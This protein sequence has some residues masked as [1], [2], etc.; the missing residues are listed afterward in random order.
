MQTYLLQRLRSI[1]AAPGVQINTGGSGASSGGIPV[2][3]DMRVDADAEDVLYP[4]RRVRDED[5][6]RRA[7]RG[8]FYDKESDG[9][10]SR[11][12][13]GGGEGGAGPEGKRPRLWKG[14]EEVSNSSSSSSSSS[15]AA[16]VGKSSSSVSTSAAAI[17]AG[18]GEDVSA[19]GV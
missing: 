18:E 1:E 12:H 7:H 14:E 9:D 11:H 2:P 10:A 5:V 19:K 15:S 6:A 8:E 3:P 13:E 17:V 4:D 16:A